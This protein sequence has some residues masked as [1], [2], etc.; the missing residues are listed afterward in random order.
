MSDELQHDDRGDRLL[1][2]TT[3]IVLSH[4]TNNA[5][6]VDQLPSLIEGV[7]RALSN[8]GEGPEAAAPKEPAV[9]I[10]SS[11]KPDHLVCLEDGK[12]F[13]LLKKHLQ[14]D[15]GMTPEEYRA[16]WGLPASYP[17]VAPNYAKWRSDHAKKMG[18]GR[19]RVSKGDN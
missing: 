19:K 1:I 4:L 17:M 6:Q 13:K 8:L 7:H 15:H 12:K 3:D 2:L 5:V 16:R 11:V 10:R 18:L 9:S 14:T